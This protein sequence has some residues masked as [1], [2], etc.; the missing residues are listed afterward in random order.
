MSYEPEQ[1]PVPTREQE[2]RMIEAIE[3]DFISQSYTDY[4]MNESLRRN[5][6][7][8]NER[9]SN[10]NRRWWGNFLVGKAHKTINGF[11][12]VSD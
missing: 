6:L 12:S 11:H 5:K 9:L 4:F 8:F 7:E 3:D 1:P 10:Y 2:I